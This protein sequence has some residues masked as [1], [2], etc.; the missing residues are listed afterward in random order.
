MLSVREA[1]VG[2]GMIAAAHKKDQ[3]CGGNAY[4]E[5]DVRIDGRLAD[6]VFPFPYIWTGGV[7]PLLWRPL[8][9]IHTL[10]VPSYV[11]DLNPWAGVL[12]DGKP[13]TIRINVLDD[14]GSW[15]MDGNLF[16]FTDSGTKHTGGKVVTD[17][18]SPEASLESSQRSV[19]TGTRFWLTASRHIRVSG[20]VDTSVGRT[21]HSFD[22]TMSFS[23]LQFVDLTT[24]EG[25]ATQTTTFKTTRS[26]S[27]LAGAVAA[28][29]TTSY[30]LVANATYPLPA[31]MKPYTLVILS[32]VH[33]GLHVRTPVGACDATANAKAT[34]K[35]IKPHVDAIATGKTVEANVCTGAFGSFS[36]HKS[37][38]DGILG[39]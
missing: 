19:G 33:Q 24:G 36:I 28:T 31:Q 10:N 12:S 26:E 17:D 35:R 2:S 14:R 23:N 34:L 6:V 29:I 27:G 25:D 1:S 16:I 3:L 32:E 7:N 11:L 22:T 9:A 38:S 5:I 18:V 4:R 8:S 39:P 30:P 20:Y 21:W 15:P 37:A 13:H